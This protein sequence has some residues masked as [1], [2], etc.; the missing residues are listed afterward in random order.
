MPRGKLSLVIR[1]PYFRDDVA[2]PHARFAART[3]V[4][5]AVATRSCTRRLPTLYCNCYEN[6]FPIPTQMQTLGPVKGTKYRFLLNSS[7]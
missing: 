7:V 3:I 4:P 2:L 1:T 6:H 5:T